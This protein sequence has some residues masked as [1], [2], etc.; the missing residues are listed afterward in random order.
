M[1]KIILIAERG[2]EDIVLLYEV[3]SIVVPMMMVACW[4]LQRPRCQVRKKLVY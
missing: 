2:I 4:E 1:L 3:S